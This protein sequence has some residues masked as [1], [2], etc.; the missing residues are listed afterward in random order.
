VARHVDALPEARD[1]EEARFGAVA[2][3]LDD[4]LARAR[5]L[6]EDSV[7]SR[8]ATASATRFITA[9]LV[10][11]ARVRPPAASMSS[12]SSSMIASSAPVSLRAGKFCGTYSSEFAA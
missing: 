2:K 7:S 5:P 10:K 3:L 11:S 4:A 6:D 8:G 12:T 9:R 1:G